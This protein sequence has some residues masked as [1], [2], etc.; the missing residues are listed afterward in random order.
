M[1]DNIELVR[2][3]AGG[4]RLSGRIIIETCLVGNSKATTLPNM[5]PDIKPA[6]PPSH[7]HVIESFPVFLSLQEMISTSS[8]IGCH[9]YLL[10]TLTEGRSIDNC[11]ISCFK[12]DQSINAT[13]GIKS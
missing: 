3:S 12:I 9:M 5:Y 1:Y 6:Q 7:T 10:L 8:C 4:G 13:V 11:Y 2:W